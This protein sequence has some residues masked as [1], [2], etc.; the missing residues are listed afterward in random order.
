MT[1]TTNPDHLVNQLVLPGPKHQVTGQQSIQI[2][3][4][5]TKFEHFAGLALQ[6]V[7][8]RDQ[9]VSDLESL[10]ERDETYVENLRQRVESCEKVL[11]PRDGEPR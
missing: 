5:L 10:A 9:L 7:M 11:L 3:G 2:V 8:S 6:G 4:G 1:K